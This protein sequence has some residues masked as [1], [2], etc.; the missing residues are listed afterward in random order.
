MSGFDLNPDPVASAARSGL[1]DA[2]KFADLLSARRYSSFVRSM[3]VALPS[4][5]LMTLGVVLIWP[6][7]QSRVGGLTV[8][9]AHVD[10]VNSELRMLAPRLTG[11]DKEGRAYT[12]TAN[13]AI[14]ERN[15]MS[16]IKMEQIDGDMTLSDGT[17]VNVTSPYG[18]YDKLL[19]RM[20]LT[21]PINVH[22]DRGYEMSAKS[23]L[24]DL[25]KSAI[26]SDEP[27]A[28]QGSFGTL[29]ADR[30][31]LEDR[32][33]H[34]YFDGNVRGQFIQSKAKERQQ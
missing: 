7:L 30:G 29:E 24:V 22:T 18:V 5:A 23:A 6:G 27:V 17:W 4:L 3:R 28:L 2:R 32:G 1:H 13:S 10:Q 21:G 25:A 20:E 15:D 16:R 34:V 26:T 9:F 12:V 14:P 31:R 33:R 11:T 8:S 19:R